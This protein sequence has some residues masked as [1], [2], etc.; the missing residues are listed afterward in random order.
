LKKLAEWQAL[1]QREFHSLI[2]DGV[3]EWMLKFATEDSGKRAINTAYD[4]LTRLNGCFQDRLEFLRQKNN[5]PAD[6]ALV[7]TTMHASKGRE[8]SA[9]AVIRAEES[10]VPDEASPETEERRLFY[11]AITRARDW[12]QISTAKKNPTSRFVVEA[13]LS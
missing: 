3:R 13:G 6:D 11:V 12:L 5:E 7:L 8:W 10:V 2:L 9:V 1:C 4:V